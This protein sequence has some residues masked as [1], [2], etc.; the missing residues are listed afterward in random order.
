MPDMF[1]LHASYKALSGSI[2]FLL[3]RRVYSTI[4]LGSKTKCII[5]TLAL[6]NQRFYHYILD[7]KHLNVI[8][9]FRY[10]NDHHSFSYALP[11]YDYMMDMFRYLYVFYDND[12]KILK[13]IHTLQKNLAEEIHFARTGYMYRPCSCGTSCM[14]NEEFNK[15]VIISK[16]YKCE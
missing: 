16:S 7:L 14:T 12:E 11:E 10:V 6:R 3:F 2:T 9:N 15:K 5:E 13:N 4:S 8:F 1:W